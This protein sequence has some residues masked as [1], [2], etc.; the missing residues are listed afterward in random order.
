MLGIGLLFYSY[1]LKTS[2]I[3]QDNILAKNERTEG[4]GSRAGLVTENLKI[5]TDYPF[6]L[7]FYGQNWREVSKKYSAFRGGLTSHNAYL[8]FITYIGPFLGIGLLIFMYYRIAKIFKQAIIFSNLRENALLVSLC[9]AFLAVSLNAL[10]HNAW[11]LTANGPTTFLYF[12][13]LHLSK[14]LPPNETSKYPTIQIFNA[15]RKQ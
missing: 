5:I 11:L 2:D 15:A 8:M 12:S 3:G 4:S 6:G 1:V 13:I 9:F 10:F 7:I 14:L